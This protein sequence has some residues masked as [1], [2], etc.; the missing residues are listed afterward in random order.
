MPPVAVFDANV[1]VSAIGWAGTPRRCID[2]A[3]DGMCH[4]ITSEPLIEE[5]MAVLR[6]KLRFSDQQLL[7]SAQYLLTFLRFVHVEGTVR[8][9][10][11]DP[12]DDMV[13]ESAMVAGATHIVSGDRRHLLPLREFQG[14]AIVSPAEFMEMMDRESAGLS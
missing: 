1:L 8:G 4:G 9:V 5:L 6:T 11:M 12:K 2:A 10:C 14:I 7:D 3:R 13:L